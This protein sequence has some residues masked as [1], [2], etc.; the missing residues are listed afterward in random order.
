MRKKKGDCP[1]LFS[2]GEGREGSVTLSTIHASKGQEYDNVVLDD[3]A[4]ANLEV[5][6]GFPRQPEE[7]NVAYV[8]ITR[9]KKTLRENQGSEQIRGQAN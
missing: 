7:I 5:S 8:G 6:E 2:R 1:F 3:D 4:I 9:A